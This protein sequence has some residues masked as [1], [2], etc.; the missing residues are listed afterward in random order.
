[1]YLCGGILKRLQV[2]FNFQHNPTVYLEPYQ[3]SMMDRF[4]KKKLLAANY[5]RKKVPSQMFDKVL[6]TPL[7]TGH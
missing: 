5:F 3:T 4:E 2:I 6:H 1:M 7:Q